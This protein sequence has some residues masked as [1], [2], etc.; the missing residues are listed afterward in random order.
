[1]SDTFDYLI[2]F[3][4]DH[5]YIEAT[6]LE[7]TKGRNAIVFKKKRRKNYKRWRGNCLNVSLCLLLM[8]IELDRIELNYVHLGLIYIYIYTPGGW[9][10]YMYLSGPV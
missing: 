9:R 1:M 8:N 3:S 6:V 7:K 2:I 10:G 5:V 4:Y